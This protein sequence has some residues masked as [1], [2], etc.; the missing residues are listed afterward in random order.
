M[1]RSHILS[2]LIFL[3]VTSSK[4]FGYLCVL[5]VTLEVRKFIRFFLQLLLFLLL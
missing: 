5:F 2:I 1:T 3:S 4:V